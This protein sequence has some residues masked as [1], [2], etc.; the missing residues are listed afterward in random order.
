MAHHA[1]WRRWDRDLAIWY[2]FICPGLRR[3]LYIIWSPI[4]KLAFIKH[5]PLLS[6]RISV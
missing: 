5:D 6:L 1:K 4:P 2:L 3:T